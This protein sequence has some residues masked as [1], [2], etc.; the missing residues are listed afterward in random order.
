[1]SGAGW[2]A[3][4][5]PN[6][7]PVPGGVGSLNNPKVLVFDPQGRFYVTDTDNHRVVRFDDMQGTGWVSFGSKGN[8]VGQFY[9]PEGI[10]LD[11]KGRIY[12][13]DNLNNRIVRIDDMTGAG[14]IALGSLPGTNE[15]QV[16]G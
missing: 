10:A 4:P 3:F 7:V 15:G 9:R 5:P 14:W 11:S 12:I 6:R 13:T 2:L 16:A 1:M 8:G